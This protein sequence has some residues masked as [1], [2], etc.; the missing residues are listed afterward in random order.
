MKLD[1][2]YHLPRH[3]TSI[4]IPPPFDR[5]CC[6][7]AIHVIAVGLVVFVLCAT[8]APWL[9][10]AIYLAVGLQSLASTNGVGRAMATLAQA[11][12]WS[13][14][15]LQ[16]QYI[17]ATIALVGLSWGLHTITVQYLK[18][19]IV[20]EFERATAIEWAAREERQQ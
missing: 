9:F 11:L 8:V 18:H 17:V 5:W 14:D 13:P 16:L 1:F 3:A 7:S 2:G 20:G 15:D 4:P 6:L 12:R 19:A 10:G